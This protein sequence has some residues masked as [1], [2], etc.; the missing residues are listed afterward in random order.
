VPLRKKN[1]SK[2]VR[3]EGTAAVATVVEVESESPEAAQKNLMIE[4]HLEHVLNLLGLDISGEHFQETP[5]RVREFLQE[6]RQGTEADLAE[7]LR[8]SFSE[9]KDNILVVQ[10]PIPFRGLCAHHL[11]PFLG[12][13]AVGYIPRER[14][15][16]L[17]KLTRL[18]QRA[19]TITPS[20]QEHITNLIA[21][22]LFDELKPIAAG[23]VTTALHG[24]MGARGVLAPNTETRVSA[25]R[26]QFLFNPTARSEFMDFVRG[27]L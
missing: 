26:G 10:V 14:V 5:R 24:C 11:A 19:G 25:L 8:T 23:C 1:K 20:T 3:L 17:S 21:D 27:K 9:T 4:A 2:E 22:T 6:Y 7:I 13:A 12:S 18:V 15:V 16:G